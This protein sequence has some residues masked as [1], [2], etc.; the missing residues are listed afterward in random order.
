MR[1]YLDMTVFQPLKN[2]GF[3]GLASVNYGTV[4]W[5][6]EIDIAPETL[7]ELSVRLPD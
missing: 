6:G 4:V 3:F 7:Y 1:P 5:P 2:P